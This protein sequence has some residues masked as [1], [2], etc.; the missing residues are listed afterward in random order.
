MHKTTKPLGFA[1]ILTLAAFSFVNQ[2]ALFYK[3]AHNWTGFVSAVSR[4]V[5]AA[6]LTRFGS[7]GLLITGQSS[8]CFAGNAPPPTPSKTFCRPSRA[9]PAGEAKRR[10]ASGPMIAALAAPGF[11]SGGLSF[12]GVASAPWSSLFFQVLGLFLVLSS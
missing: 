2:A 4:P 12:R 1:G 3:L 8:S 5:I 9:E 6:T 7:A 10:R 11:Y